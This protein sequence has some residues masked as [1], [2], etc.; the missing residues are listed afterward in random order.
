MRIFR[1]FCLV[2]NGS[3]LDLCI[4]G[5]ALVRHVPI[6]A[7]DR[8]RPNLT[9]RSNLERTQ[10]EAQRMSIFPEIVMLRFPCDPKIDPTT[11]FFF[12]NPKER[13]SV[14]TLGAVCIFILSN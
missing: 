10:S 13:T 6:E 4:C 9:G 5:T 3:F 11:C 7:T 1:F 8:S 12:V 2:V 14:K